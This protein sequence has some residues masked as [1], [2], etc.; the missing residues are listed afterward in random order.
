MAIPIMHENGRVN[1][2]FLGDGLLAYFGFTQINN[3]Q[4]GGATKGIK[5]YL[6]DIWKAIIN[7]DIDIDIKCGIK[8]GYVLLGI[9]GSM[10]VDHFPV[11]GTHVNLG[12]RLEGLAE[13]DQF[14]LPSYDIS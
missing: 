12:G 13:E 11:I 14:I 5:Q 2:N 6:T 8:I 7:C 3:D 9:S 4:S 10:V 1:N